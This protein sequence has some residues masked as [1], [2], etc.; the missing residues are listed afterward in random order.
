[1]NLLI[2]IIRGIRRVPGGF[3][4]LL[5]YLAVLRP[6]FFIAI[7]IVYLPLTAARDWMPRN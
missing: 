3:R 6:C 7:V 1:M 4:H 5:I 2:R